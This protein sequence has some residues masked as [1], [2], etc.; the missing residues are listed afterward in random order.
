[1][2]K[3]EDDTIKGLY[4]VPNFLT[5]EEHKKILDY[6][7]KSK[8][9]KGVGKNSGSRKVI[10]FGYSYAYDRSGI[11]KIDDV[12]DYFK[13]LVD[14]DRV[15]ANIETDLLDENMEQLII[16]E[17]KPGQGIHPHLDHVGYFGAII[18]CITIGSGVSMD[19]T[20]IEDPTKKKTI[21]VQPSSLYI[22]SGDARYKWKH[23]IKRTSYDNG[24]KRGTR[25]SLTYRTVQIDNLKN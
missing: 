2:N 6:L 13:N 20:K 8:K 14:I 15:N 19:F 7:K 17:Y 16:N 25:Y 5:D 11:K 21:F 23:G 1:M 12:P 18:V 3:H 22:M 10:H 9:W 24:K 4:Y